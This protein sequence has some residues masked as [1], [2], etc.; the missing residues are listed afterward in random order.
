MGLVAL[1]VVVGG[2]PA[3]ARDDWQLWLEQRW[4]VELS[5]HVKLAGKAEERLRDNMD[6]FLSQLTS[7]WVSWKPLSWL[8]FEPGYCSVENPASRGLPLRHPMRPRRA[9]LS[10]SSA[11]GAWG[12]WLRVTREAS[13]GL[14]DR[15]PGYHYQWTEGVGARDTNEH[16]VFLNVTPSWSRGRVSIEDRHRLEFRHINGRE[17]WRYRNK[18]KLSVKVGRG[19]WAMSPYVSD[20]VF[21]GHRA[22]EWNRNRVFL[23]VEKP[24]TTQVS[25]D[26]YYV[27]ESNRKGRDWE[28][29]HVL[30]LAMSVAL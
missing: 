14:F 24:L 17:D 8:K 5:P 28:E 25:T 16:R 11:P 18:S 10:P 9:G 13:E 26:V 29:F 23:G 15:A 6:E 20:E 7:V 27:L 4:S 30:G 21:Y 19:W 12:P 2:V 3:Q 22:G 1:G